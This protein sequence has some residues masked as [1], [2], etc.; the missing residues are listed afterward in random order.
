MVKSAIALITLI[1]LYL[2]Y[3]AYYKTKVAKNLENIIANG[4]T[5]LDVR[6]I[7]EF[8]KGHL[9]NAIN[10]PVRNLKDDAT[11]TDKN[12]VIITYC[13]HV[14]RSYNAVTILKN[15]GYE[16][17]FNGGALKHLKQFIVY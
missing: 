7:T 5:L 14:I 8:N 3:I 13:S 9:K 16:K 12:E 1:I 11:L 6:T 15:K 10:I 17:V 2:L 4:T